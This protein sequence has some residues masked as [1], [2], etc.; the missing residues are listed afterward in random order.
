[1]QLIVTGTYRITGTYITKLYTIDKAK[2][3]HSSFCLD[4]IAVIERGYENYKFKVR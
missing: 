2:C 3:I 4:L 1:M